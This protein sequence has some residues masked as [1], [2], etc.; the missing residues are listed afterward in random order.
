MVPALWLASL[1]DAGIVE[2]EV[3]WCRSRA[4]STTGYK[5]SCLR[6]EKVRTVHSRRDRDTQYCGFS[7][8]FAPPDFITA[9]DAP[10]GALASPPAAVHRHACAP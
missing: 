5:L 10:L 7:T 6:H 8:F 4:R 9:E 3:R 1:Q 2:A